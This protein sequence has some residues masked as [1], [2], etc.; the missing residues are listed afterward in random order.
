M[1]AI[2]EPFFTTKEV[3]KGTGLGLSQSFGFAQQSGGEIE[4]VSALGQG[5][6]FTLYLPQAGAPKSQPQAVKRSAGAGS[7]PRGHWILVVEDNKDVGEFST[8]MLHDLGYKTR[9]VASAREALDLLAEDKTAFDLVFSDVIMPG[10]NGVDLAS[11]LRDAYPGL[12]V[13]LTSG[14]SHVLAEN[15]GHG[16]ELVQKPYSVEALSRVLRR[17]IAEREA[18]RR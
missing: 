2:F 12:P 10:M 11:A 3:G 18:I 9:W 4:V 16:F 14:Y 5:S 8:E 13:I 6:T 7:G 15:G 1:E 17:A